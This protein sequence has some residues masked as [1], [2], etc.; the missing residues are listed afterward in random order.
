MFERFFKDIFVSA[1][2]KFIEDFDASEGLE[3][4]K[5]NGTITKSNL[6]FKQDAL[7]HVGLREMLGAPLLVK[8]G[9][10]GRLHIEIPWSEILSRP[11]KVKLTDLHVV[12]QTPGSYDRDFVKRA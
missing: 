12:L 3:I 1:L 6:V 4:D 7:E 10:L 8:K 5:W 11:C 9:V 2:S